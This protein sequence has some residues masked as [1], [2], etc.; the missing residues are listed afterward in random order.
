MSQS[1]QPVQGTGEKPRM[2]K[3][4]MKPG[5]G[6]MLIGRGWRTTDGALARSV[7][8]NPLER[9]NPE[10]EWLEAR[11]MDAEGNALEG[12]IKEVPFELVARLL[13]KD[14]KPSRVIEGYPMAKT[15]GGLET[16][17]TGRAVE[18]HVSYSPKAEPG[19]FDDVTFEIVR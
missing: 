5:C 2:V 14:G 18:T 7:P 8:Q 1:Q 3:I 15:S 4:R 17:A 10:D 12:P 11:E 9:L 19:K 6:R 13:G 16:D